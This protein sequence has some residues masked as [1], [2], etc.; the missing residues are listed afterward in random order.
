MSEESPLQEHL[1]DEQKAAFM[2]MRK[3]DNIVLI[4][5]MFEGKKASIIAAVFDDAEDDNSVVLMP[6]YVE[7]T[8][9]VMMRL[10]DC[11]GDTPT[12]TVNTSPVDQRFTPKTDLGAGEHTLSRKR[13]KLDS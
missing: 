12:A 3:A 4:D 8:E 1:T 6:L 10:Q 13:Q 5:G 7:C 9:S 2:Q 11:Q